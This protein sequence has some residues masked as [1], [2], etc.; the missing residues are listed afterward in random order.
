MSDLHGVD[1]GYVDALLDRF[2]ADRTQRSATAL[3]AALFARDVIAR[4]AATKTRAWRARMVA[5]ADGW[6]LRALGTESRRA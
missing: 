1:L 4:L 2:D 3:Y 6:T 5:A